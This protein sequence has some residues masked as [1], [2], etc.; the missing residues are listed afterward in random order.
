MVARTS[1]PRLS[2]VVQYASALGISSEPLKIITRRQV[3]GN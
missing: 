2:R 1:L 3:K